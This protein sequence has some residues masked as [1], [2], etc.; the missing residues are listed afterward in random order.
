MMPRRHAYK[1][2]LRYLLS[3]D[4]ANEVVLWARTDE[5]LPLAVDE[6]WRIKMEHWHGFML[7]VDVEQGTPRV[8]C[9]VPKAHHPDAGGAPWAR[10]WRIGC[11]G[12]LSPGAE[13]AAIVTDAAAFAAMCWQLRPSGR[14]SGLAERATPMRLPWRT[15]S[16]R[17]PPHPADFSSR[18]VAAASLRFGP[19]LR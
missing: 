16:C 19:A 4:L 13:G 14:P 11:S 17:L 2:L 18:S 15:A 7:R 1:G 12:R 6:P 9:G 10:R 8:R 3:H 5:P